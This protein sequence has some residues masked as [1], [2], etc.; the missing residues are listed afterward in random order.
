M[1]RVVLDTNVFISGILTPKGYPGKI[2]KA[3]REQKFDLVVS[4]KILEEIESVLKYEKIAHRH[5]WSDREITAFVKSIRLFAVMTPGKHKT[6]I[7]FIEHE[8]EK[9]LAASYEGKADYL[10]TGDKRLLS[11]RIYEG[12]EIITPKK[13]VEII[14]EG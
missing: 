1:I 10:I 5:G 8:D 3:W 12:T 9:F 13:F 14:L 11:L 6:G 2:L 7:S 4:E